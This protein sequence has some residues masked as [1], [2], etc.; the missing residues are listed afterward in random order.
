MLVDYSSRENHVEDLDLLMDYTLH[1]EVRDASEEG[2]V[3]PAQHDKF[4]K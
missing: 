4:Y 2:H 1:D 3:T